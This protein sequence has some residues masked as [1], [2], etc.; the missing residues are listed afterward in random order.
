M[1]FEITSEYYGLQNRGFRLWYFL[2]FFFSQ[3]KE[4][5]EFCNF[6]ETVFKVQAI[7]GESDLFAHIDGK[8]YFNQTK[9]TVREVS[10]FIFLSLF[11]IIRLMLFRYC[12]GGQ[13]N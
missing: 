11:K 13:I 1:V 4:F 7:F 9:D 6:L 3:R 8:S 5:L 10:L 12:L 2:I